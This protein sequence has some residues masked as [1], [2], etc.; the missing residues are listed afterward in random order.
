MASLT[1]QN[2]SHA[3]QHLPYRDSEWDRK[4][5]N[6]LE[7]LETSAALGTDSWGTV[8]GSAGNATTSD[9]RSSAGRIGGGSNSGSGAVQPFG[10]AMSSS[11]NFS[12]SSSGHQSRQQA[13]LSTS[14]SKVRSYSASRAQSA[15]SSTQRNQQGSSGFD[16]LDTGFPLEKST[17]GNSLH[18]SADNML[19][20]LE[21]SLKA[22]TNYIESHR[23]HSGPTGSEEYHEYRA[24]SNGGA[25]KTDF[26]LE[27]QV[28]HM[29]PSGNMGTAPNTALSTNNNYNSG[30]QSANMISSMQH[31]KSS[32]SSY[33]VN[34]VQTNSYSS[35]GDRMIQQPQ[36]PQQQPPP[37]R[38]GQSD[39]ERPGSRLKQNIDELDNLLDDL[40]NAKK[41][42][43]TGGDYTAS[44]M[45]SDDYSFSEGHQGHVKK[46]SQSYN[47]SDYNAYSNTNSEFSSR[48]PPSPSPRR[49]GPTPVLASPSTVRRMSP[50]PSTTRRPMD[51]PP[52]GPNGINSSYS[53]NYSSHNTT[54]NTGGYN[55]SNYPP[56]Q[57]ST[58]YTPPPP[59][60]TYQPPPLQS[61]YPPPQT[62][63]VPPQT[64]YAPP[65]SS[66]L[67]R[68]EDTPTGVSY[69]TK[70]HSTH[71]HQSQG[72]GPASFPSNSTPRPA[73]KQTPPK[74]VDDL[75]NELSEFDSSI[76]HSGFVEP[77][78][79]PR[80]PSPEPYRPNYRE[81]SPTRPQQNLQPIRPAG[82]ELITH[83]TS[84]QGQGGKG[85]AKGEYQYKSKGKSKYSESEG[86]KKGAAVIPICLPLCCAAPC[87][88]M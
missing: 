83:T 18:K 13:L 39:D 2:N 56:Q 12:Q 4:L 23:S 53:Y 28:Q 87:V 10:G 9:N 67:S 15:S 65:P 55:P 26:N 63:Y 3:Q 11:S 30:L 35:N 72:Q 17:S 8:G 60:S 34:K 7:D 51:G 37:I 74:R 1:V 54:S 29:M 82:G 40:N 27:R 43:D 64:T 20:D 84:L 46:T 85:K 79:K 61:A 81:L 80:T 32:S 88:I 75:M 52:M 73:I 66:D 59:V 38:Y 19:K 42:S 49:R 21:G 36:P 69:Y 14:S 5:D 76:A 62:S 68:N 33:Y 31:S 22:S 70:Y 48:K 25:P 58:T 47:M 6:M 78:H 50:S 16:H 45:S 86:G 71:S 57:P 77:R 41:M 44:G 24:Y